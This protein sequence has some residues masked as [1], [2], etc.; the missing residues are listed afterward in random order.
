[1]QHFLLFYEFC[2]DYLARRAALRSEHLT[3]AWAAQER[4]ELVLAGAYGD[5]I[6]GGLLLFKCVSPAIPL[7][8]AERDPY[9]RNGL[10]VAYRVHP[11][12]TVVGD[13]ATT[14]VRQ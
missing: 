3:L 1:M 12:A 4:G 2:E 11:W 13:T 7:A 9:V 8:F 14:P 5:P 10:V 6:D